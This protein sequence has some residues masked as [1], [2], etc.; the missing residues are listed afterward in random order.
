M[1]DLGLKEE[2]QAFDKYDKRRQDGKTEVLRLSA[3]QK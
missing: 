2:L 1:D 3:E